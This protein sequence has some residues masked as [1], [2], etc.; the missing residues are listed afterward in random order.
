M[1]A[2]LKA[3]WADQQ[4]PGAEYVNF[5]IYKDG[6]PLGGVIPLPPTPSHQEF[7]AA[8]YPASTYAANVQG[9]YPP[10]P[11]TI[12]VVGGPGGPPPHP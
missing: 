5:Q 12:S 2:T 8:D 11:C 3:D 9:V 1:A 7:F 4:F 6:S 10:F